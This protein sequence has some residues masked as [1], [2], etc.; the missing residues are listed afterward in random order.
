LISLRHGGEEAVGEGE[1]VFEVGAAEDFLAEW[2]G[3]LRDGDD[4]GVLPRAMGGPGGDE[5]GQR[6]DGEEV[7]EAVIE[8][9]GEADFEAAGI[10]LGLE[11]KEVDDAEIA[12]RWDGLGF[13]SGWMG[14][15]VGFVSGGD[16]G[17]L[18]RGEAGA[19]FAAGA[20]AVREEA[21]AEAVGEMA[22]GGA[23]AAQE[24]GQGGDGDGGGG[25]LD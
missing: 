21:V 12:I 8:L 2:S 11:L 5:P 17:G 18:L 14:G 7:L 6:G 13:W 3:A 25:L 24:R 4:G 10:E 16:C 22:N 1:G 15:D 20:N 19:F 9:I 23:G